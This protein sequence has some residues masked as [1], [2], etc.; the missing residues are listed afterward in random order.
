M[1][2][3]KENERSCDMDYPDV[4][5]FS[6]Q[7]D[8]LICIDS[9]GTAM[10]AMNIKHKKCFGPCFVTE[11]GLKDHQD[12][13]LNIWNEVNLYSST[14]GFNRFITFAE[15]LQ[16]IDGKYLAV[17]ELKV[18]KSWI[19]TAAELSNRSL[20]EEIE[21]KDSPILEKALNWSLEVNKEI[22]KLTS[23]DNKPFEGVKECLHFAFDK[24]DISVISS[25]NMGAI[26]KE[27]GHFNMLKYV[28]AMT[29]QEIG[30][31][32]QCIA[33]M[34]KKGYSAENVLMIGD[35]F[36]DVDAA[37]ETG[38]FFYP[39]VADHEKECWNDLMEFYLDEFRSGN[40]IKHQEKLLQKFYNNF[41][42]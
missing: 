1:C 3:S 30:T 16:R 9:D 15:V 38:V 23:N 17:N 7:H 20:K 37:K 2:N 33:K 11:L 22:A 29:S 21:K 31:K 41:N 24:V 28:G 5:E 27:W 42:K 32:G 8:Y 13:V 34:L 6:K 36:P 19:E 10:D 18:L 35:A 25:A 40:Y 14:R 12:E 4:E 26:V 39:I